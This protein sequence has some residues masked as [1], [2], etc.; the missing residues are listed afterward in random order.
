MLHHNIFYSSPGHGFYS[1]VS[2]GIRK[3]KFDRQKTGINT[4]MFFPVFLQ[5]AFLPLGATYSCT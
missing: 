4:G 1:D 5:Y 3:I 2:A